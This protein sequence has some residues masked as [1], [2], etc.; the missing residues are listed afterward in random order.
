MHKQEKAE[1]NVTAI[2]ADQVPLWKCEELGYECK[3][4]SNKA[5]G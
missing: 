3:G 5:H 2:S 1:Q 4:L